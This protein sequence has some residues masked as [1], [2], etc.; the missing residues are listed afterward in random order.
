MLEISIHFDPSIFENVPQFIVGS[1]VVEPIDILQFPHLKTFLR[2][3]MESIILPWEAYFGKQLVCLKSTLLSCI[4]S[5]S[6]MAVPN[7]RYRLE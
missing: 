3:L 2:L 1:E 4:W 6:A 7:E 5:I